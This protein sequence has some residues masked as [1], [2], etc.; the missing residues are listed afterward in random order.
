MVSSRP[1]AM[2][3]IRHADWP[4][5]W[6]Q[7]LEGVCT[8]VCLY[9]RF[10]SDDGAGWG[11][12]PLSA[13]RVWEAA[14]CSTTSLVTST[15]ER[16]ARLNSTRYQRTGR[17]VMYTSCQVTG[18]V[19]GRRGGVGEGGGVRLKARAGAVAGLIPGPRGL[20]GY[21]FWWTRGHLVMKEKY[22]E[23]SYWQESCYK[24]V[25]L[26][27]IRLLKINNHSFVD[28][29]K[30]IY[31]LFPQ[32][33]S[34]GDF[35]CHYYYYYHYYISPCWERFNFLADRS[36]SVINSPQVCSWYLCEPYG[37]L[38]LTYRM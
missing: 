8:H 14:R 37:S 22:N 5:H 28:S 38:L 16:R 36:I 13:Q 20:K 17:D 9:V 3:L 33:D 2:Y 12:V 4:T 32:E 27:L 30:C 11:Q 6:G 7:N 23:G 1:S 29:V 24:H 34:A 31:S 18:E 15:A 19:W 21:F 10:Q 25:F 26:I 35:L